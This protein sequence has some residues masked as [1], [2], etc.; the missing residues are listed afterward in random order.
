M[1]VS[2]IQVCRFG[3]RHSPAWSHSNVLLIFTELLCSD[4]GFVYMTK[5]LEAARRRKSQVP[6]AVNEHP[7]E[8]PSFPLKLTGIIFDS[9]PAILDPLIATRSARQATQHRHT[10][11]LKILAS[12]HQKITLFCPGSSNPVPTAIFLA[13]QCGPSNVDHPQKTRTPSF[14]ML[15]R[16]LDLVQDWHGIAALTGVQLESTLMW[17]VRCKLRFPGP[18]NDVQTSSFLQFRFFELP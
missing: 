17:S 10:H 5:V 18:T 7:A 9:A 8:D 16:K 15:T 12:M 6:E 2:C 11:L 14:L 13:V 1:S 3:G 4:A